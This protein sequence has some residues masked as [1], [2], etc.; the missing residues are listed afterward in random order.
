MERSKHQDLIDYE[1]L[2][3]PVGGKGELK[4]VAAFGWFAGGESGEIWTSGRL[5]N[6]T[7]RPKR[8]ERAR[9]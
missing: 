6:F 1:L 5:L 7:Y 2:T 9:H 3:A 8:L 4:R